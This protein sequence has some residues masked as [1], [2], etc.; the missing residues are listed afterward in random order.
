MKIKIWSWERQ[1]AKNSSTSSYSD[2]SFTVSSD[3]CNQMNI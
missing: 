3:Y 1:W 2:C